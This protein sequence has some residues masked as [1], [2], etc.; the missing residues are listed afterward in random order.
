MT[1]YKQIEPLA[2]GAVDAAIKLARKQ[3]VDAPDKVN[4][5]KKDVPAILFTPV[6]VDKSN[7]DS[8]VI[9]DKYHSHED[10]YG[11]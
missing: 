10:I 11:H 2:F 3:P 6:I 5:G 9:K 7:V 1:V 8:T 4:N